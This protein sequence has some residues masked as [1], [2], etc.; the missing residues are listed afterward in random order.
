M[1]LLLLF[2][3]GTPR[4]L[5]QFIEIPFATKHSPPLFNRKPNLLE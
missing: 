3:G 2:F 4:L 1:N 5:S